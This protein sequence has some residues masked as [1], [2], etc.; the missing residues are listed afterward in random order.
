MQRRKKKITNPPHFPISIQHQKNALLV[1]L[2]LL[3]KT[4]DNWSYPG[5]ILLYKS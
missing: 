1:V 5:S 3:K 2:Q 4:T